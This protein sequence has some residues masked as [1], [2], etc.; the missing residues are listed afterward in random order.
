MVN[1]AAVALAWV[2]V[3]FYLEVGNGLLTGLRR[4]RLAPEESRT[5]SL[6]RAAR[7]EGVTLAVG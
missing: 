3:H 1:D 7:A 2:P 4:G 5:D 6:A